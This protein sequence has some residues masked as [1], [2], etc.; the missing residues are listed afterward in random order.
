MF[1]IK[2]ISETYCGDCAD[3]LDADY[4]IIESAYDALQVFVNKEAEL[5]HYDR[6]TIELDQHV[7]A[8]MDVL[9]KD[10]DIEKARFSIEF[11]C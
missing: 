10:G 8:S 6:P 11:C 7:G 2:K 3:I 5:G 1:K 9:I 4:Q